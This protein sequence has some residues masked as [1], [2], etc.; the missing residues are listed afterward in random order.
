MPNTKKYIVELR[1]AC[2][3]WAIVSCVLLVGLWFA[4]NFFAKLGLQLEEHN[5]KKIQTIDNIRTE[6]IVSDQKLSKEAIDGLRLTTIKSLVP[7]ISGTLGVGT[8]E[9]QK[10]L[11]T[12]SRITQKDTSEK[13]YITWLQ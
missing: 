6:G 7:S 8:T 1:N 3:A 9:E 4:F 12:I 11:A 2:I 13:D 5:Q 10:N